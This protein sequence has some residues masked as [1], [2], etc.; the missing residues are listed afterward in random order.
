MLDMSTFV[1]AS[2]IGRRV[3]TC[4]S[5]DKNSKLSSVS[6]SKLISRN[7]ALDAAASQ[8]L[9]MHLI[10]LVTLRLEFAIFCRI[11]AGS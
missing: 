5:L 10:A 9:Q 2:F 4:L 8:L 11:S 6:Y 3:K 7:C 1:T